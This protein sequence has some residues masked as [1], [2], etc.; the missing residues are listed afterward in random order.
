[1]A[2]EENG[3]QP[4]PPSAPDI[5]ADEEENDAE[6]A[7]ELIEDEPLSPVDELLRSI[8]KSSDLTLY[9]IR[10]PDP[11]GMNI[12]FRDQCVMKHTKGEIPYD[13]S[14]KS[15]EAID[16]VIQRLYGGGKYQ[17]QLRRGGYY[18][19]AWT[20][21]VADVPLKP[22]PH[23]PPPPPPPIVSD[24]MDHLR[25]S[26]AI[27][28]EFKDV[29]G[30]NQ[31]PQQQPPAL[32]PANPAT[33]LSD[34]V[35]MVKT[36]SETVKSLQ[37]E[38]PP[39]AN[40]EGS[41]GVAIVQTVG[42]ILRDPSVTPVLGALAQ[43][44]MSMAQ[45]TAGPPKEV[46]QLVETLVHQITRNNDPLHSAAHVV[47]FLRQYPQ[48]QSVVSQFANQS[49][50]EVLIQMSQLKPEFAHIRELPHAP[51]WL[52]RFRNHLIAMLANGN[53]TVSESAPTT[54]TPEA[55]APTPNGSDAAVSEA[56]L[57]F[58]RLLRRCA[59]DMDASGNCESADCEDQHEHTG[60]PCDESVAVEMTLKLVTQ[61][62]EFVPRLQIVLMARPQQLVEFVASQTQD[63]ALVQNPGSILFARDFQNSLRAALEELEAKSEPPV[64]PSQPEAVN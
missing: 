18:E 55:P 36:I 9:V 62:P 35:T 43:W 37:P 64:V 12:D 51:E 47:Q 50:T 33:Q 34:A 5:E 25:N 10:L 31:R 2:D 21:L 41:L 24:P 16:L 13:E 39:V 20:T 49:A 58:K 4:P 29:L 3:H 63:A 8:E 61:F 26:F 38:P 23:A 19:R 42:S 46:T 32:E 53:Q 15:K 48:F 59:A 27:V 11:V 60:G 7:G 22:E 6:E 57:A 30:L 40:G 17:V 52:N 14:Y 1:M 56:D 54:P 44:L 28:R 45:G